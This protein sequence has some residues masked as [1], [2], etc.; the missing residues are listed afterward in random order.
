V[1]IYKIKDGSKKTPLHRE[2]RHKINGEKKGN[3]PIYPFSSK[4]VRLFSTLRFFTPFLPTG[5]TFFG[6]R[7]RGWGLIW[8]SSSAAMSTSPSSSGRGEARAA[9]DPS[10]SVGCVVDGGGRDTRITWSVR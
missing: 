7:F 3:I 8:M 5:I 9:G 4:L 10:E 1:S 6:F 2:N